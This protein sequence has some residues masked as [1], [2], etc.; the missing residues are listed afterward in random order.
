MDGYRHANR[1]DSAARRAG[2]GSD[3]PP[4]LTLRGTCA[5]FVENGKIV[6]HREYFDQLELYTQLGLH[7]SKDNPAPT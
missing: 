4:H 7:L 5:S 3:R 1:T 2:T 6:T